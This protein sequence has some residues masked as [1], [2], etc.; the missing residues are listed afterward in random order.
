M[1]KN[2]PEMTKNR[3]VAGTVNEGREA[4]GRQAS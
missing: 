1:T 2:R 3:I 4:F